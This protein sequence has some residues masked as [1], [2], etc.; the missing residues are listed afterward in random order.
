MGYTEMGL[1]VH[2]HFIFGMAARKIP[3]LG[4]KTA[5]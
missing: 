1:S 4:K 2:P 3:G 5:P